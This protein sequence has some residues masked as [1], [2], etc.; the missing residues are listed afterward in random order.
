MAD[1]RFNGK[2]PLFAV[3][4]VDYPHNKKRFK[5]VEQKMRFKILNSLH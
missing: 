1:L 5:I 4:K 2:I 3:V